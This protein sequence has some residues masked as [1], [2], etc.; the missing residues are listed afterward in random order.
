[1]IKR[2]KDSIVELGEILYITEAVIITHLN[3]NEESSKTTQLQVL[4]DF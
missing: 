4:V 1:M 2:T 3:P